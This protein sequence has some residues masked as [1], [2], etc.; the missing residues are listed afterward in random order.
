[1]R[2]PQI[3]DAVDERLTAL[4]DLPSRA[5]T[6]S[7]VVII[8][9]ATA[10]GRALVGP[11]PLLAVVG[12]ASH[13]SRLPAAQLPADVWQ[14]EASLLSAVMGF[15]F[16]RGVVALAERPRGEPPGLTAALARPAWTIVVVE[17]LAD[18][19]NVGAIVRTAAVLGVDAVV[20]D[21]A[22]ADPFARRALRASMGHAL[23]DPPWVAEDL[24]AAVARLSDAGG[25]IVATTTDSTATSLPEFVAA[26]KTAV[27]FGNEGSGLSAALAARADA[28]VTIPIAPGSDSLNVA[29]A[30]AIVAY[31]LRG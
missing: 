9:G 22:G 8:E 20:C 24:P 13:L 10:V 12:T 6:R 14:V 1:M 28:A 30:V 19:A 26:D 7:E 29:A 21:A 4:R 15:D 17:R 25:Q 31:A 23:V 2:W 3:E 16:H 27:L 18:P 11:L 5:G